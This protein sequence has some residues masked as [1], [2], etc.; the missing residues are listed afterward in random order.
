MKTSI[1]LLW[2]F[3]LNCAVAETS[4]WDLYRDI[5]NRDND[6]E[7]TVE[8][9]AWMYEQSQ[10]NVEEIR[11]MNRRSSFSVF[12]ELNNGKPQAMSLGNDGPNG[13]DAYGGEFVS[14][15]HEIA[16]EMEKIE[17]SNFE[18]DLGEFKKILKQVIV[19]SDEGRY[20]AVNGQPVDALNFPNDK[21]ILIN[22]ERWRQMGLK[23]KLR[24]VLHEYLGILNVERN[25]YKVS[26]KMNKFFDDLAGKLKEKGEQLYYGL[27]DA[28]LPLS[29]KGEICSL[30][31]PQLEASI[32]CAKEK[33]LRRCLME[34][35]TECKG[36]VI[37]KQE[38][39]R[40]IGVATC[41]I[42]SIV[43]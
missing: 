24:L 20:I 9:P 19:Y 32:L 36:Q 10:R 21:K 35:Y 4:T 26:M 39:M 37:I 38:K 30:E 23:E 11:N 15:G 2:I 16:S 14:L 13:G 12:I 27:C 1:L 29:F 40:A 18:V 28:N 41:E 5:M 6:E 8:I 43:K 17:R 7:S 22:R 31:N 3:L 25:V 42:T 34:S 33:A